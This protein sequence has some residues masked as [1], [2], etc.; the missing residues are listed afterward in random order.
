MAS[1]G[2]ARIPSDKDGCRYN[3]A[4]IK[5]VD[6]DEWAIY[7]T[8]NTWEWETVEKILDHHPYVS[9]LP[10]NAHLKYMRRISKWAYTQ[11]R[12]DYGFMEFL[13]YRNIIPTSF[14][15]REEMTRWILNHEEEIIEKWYKIKNRK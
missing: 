14:K 12:G 9:D 3:V 5:W 4:H 8:Y 11:A 2:K 1:E 13:F 15:T 10:K 6:C 7:K